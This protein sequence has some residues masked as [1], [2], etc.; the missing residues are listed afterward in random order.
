MRNFDVLRRH[1]CQTGLEKISKTKR[2]ISAILR[3]WRVQGM[4]YA[5]PGE[6][7]PRI[8]CL[9]QKSSPVLKL[10]KGNGEAILSVYVVDERL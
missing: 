9:K 1:L 6:H 3:A 5:G 7:S 2:V 10:D 4:P 8:T